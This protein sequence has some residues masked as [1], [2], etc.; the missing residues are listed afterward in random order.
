MT[1]A[2]F[3]VEKRILLNDLLSLRERAKKL[4]EDR[5]AAEKKNLIK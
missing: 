5:P 2:E 4:E 1:P 3:E